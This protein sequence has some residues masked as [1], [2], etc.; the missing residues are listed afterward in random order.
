MQKHPFSLSQRPATSQNETAEMKA[1]F[2]WALQI[3]D[4]L[5][6]PRHVLLATV[7]AWRVFSSEDGDIDYFFDDLEEDITTDYI[8]ARRRR[9]LS[10]QNIKKMVCELREYHADMV[11]LIE[12]CS[13]YK[14]AVSYQMTLTRVAKL[15]KRLL[16]TGLQLELNLTLGQKETAE[17]SEF[18]SVFTV[19]V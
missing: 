16:T 8:E 15:L 4:L 17:K 13:N 1:A 7:E 18:T 3:M 11:A 2:D 19:T 10:M 5:Q 14:K 6:K 12:K 9:Y